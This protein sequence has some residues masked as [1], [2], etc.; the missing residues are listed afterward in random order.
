MKNS[1][2]CQNL[3]FD[4]NLIK[5]KILKFTY[6]FKNLFFKKSEKIQNFKLVF[7]G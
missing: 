5:I 4:L 1:K 6:F 7:N 3:T 2:K